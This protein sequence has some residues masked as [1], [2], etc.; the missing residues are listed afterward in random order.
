M[1]SL[2]QLLL[3]LFLSALPKNHSETALDA[4]SLQTACLSVDSPSGATLTELFVHDL[5]NGFANTQKWTRR[6]T[7]A[8]VC[9]RVLLDHALS[10]EQFRYFL[11]PHLIAMADD[12]VVNVRIAV[13]RAL[14]LCDSSVQSHAIA[15]DSRRLSPLTVETVLERLAA[16]ADMDVA[17]AARQAMGQTVGNET[18]DVSMRGFRIRERENAFLDVHL[19]DNYEEDDMS[20]CSDYTNSETPTRNK[21]M[22]LSD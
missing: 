19:V 20:L 13:C 4:I 16:D 7:F 12:S 2:P 6:Q 8:Y 5:V 22:G 15:S 21:Q 17:R 3:E 11:L 18:V 9:E 1:G 10:M 14:S